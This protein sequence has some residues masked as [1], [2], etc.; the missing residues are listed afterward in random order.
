MRPDDPLA[1]RTRIGPDDL[2]AAHLIRPPEQSTSRSH[3]DRHFTGLGITRTA[4]SDAGVADWATAVHLAEL[5][6]GH[7]LVPELPG[8]RDPDRSGGPVLVPVPDL[9]PL[10]VGWAVRRW[11]TLTPLARAFAD[12]V[13][14]HCGR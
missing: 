3:L 13:A 2:A 9:P 14:E 1:G 8:W 7:A 6:L 4:G 11:A 5:G 10:A 12:L